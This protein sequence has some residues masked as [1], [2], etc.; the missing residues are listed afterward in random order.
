MK[1][2]Q[3]P[4]WLLLTLTLPQAILFLL[5]WR[6]HRI[7]GT[8]LSPESVTAARGAYSLAARAA[9]RMGVGTPTPDAARRAQPQAV[10]HVVCRIRN[11]YD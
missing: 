10:P 7:I 8:L 4:F 5:F 1:T 2:V 6:F 9:R 11:P 3:R